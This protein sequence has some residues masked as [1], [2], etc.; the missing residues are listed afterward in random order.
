MIRHWQNLGIMLSAALLCLALIGCGRRASSTGQGSGSPMMLDG[1][2][3]PVEDV[4]AAIASD[5]HAIEKEQFD[6]YCD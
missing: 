6:E 2:S 1:I 5:E 4:E 3:V